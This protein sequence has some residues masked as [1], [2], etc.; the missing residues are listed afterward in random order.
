MELLLQINDKCYKRNITA[1]PTYCSQD[2]EQPR[3]P[4]KFITYLVEAGKRNN[5]HNFKHSG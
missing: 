5:L 3:F 4:K 1:T 2:L